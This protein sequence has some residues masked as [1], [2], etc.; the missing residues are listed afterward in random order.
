MSA[1]PRRLPDR[2]SIEQ[3]RKQAK[4]RLDALRE[5]DPSVK[6]SAAQHALARDYGFESWPKLLH[7]IESLQPR[8]HMLQPPALKSD[9]KLLWSAGRG[10]DVWKLFEACIAG[11]LPAVQALIADD[12]SLVRAHY[13]YRKPL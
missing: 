1:S 8:H 6:L 2:P 3:L 5:T 11:D 10:T 4:E 7:H 9:Q 12:P 13:N